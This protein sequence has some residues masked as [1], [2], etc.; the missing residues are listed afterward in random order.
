MKLL[1][2]KQ[3]TVKPRVEAT[4]STRVRSLVRL[5]GLAQSQGA[6]NTRVFPY[7]DS[8]KCP[9]K[10]LYLYWLHSEWW[11]RTEIPPPTPP[12]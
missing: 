10:P 4:A 3:T 11:R 6:A 2:K 5:I 9:I 1:D 12:P 7:S 8:K